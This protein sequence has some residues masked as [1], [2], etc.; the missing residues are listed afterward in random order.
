MALLYWVTSVSYTHLDVYKRQLIHPDEGRYAELSLGMLQSGDW[1]TPRLNGILYFEK[2]ALQ[3]W[4]GALSFL[5][6]GINEFSARFWPGL[7]GLLS[8]LVV[9]LTSRRLWGSGHYAALVMGGAFWVI[10]LSLIH[11]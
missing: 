9:G 5:A 6:F 3:Y 8:V 10:G 11:I 4:T 1:I 7:T 2:P